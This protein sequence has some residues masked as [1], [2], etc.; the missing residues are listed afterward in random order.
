VIGFLRF[1]GVS[2]AAIWLGAVFFTMVEVRPSLFSPEMETLLGAGNSTFF[3]YLSGAIAQI[4]WLRCF[5][6]QIVCAGIAWL[7]GLAEWL[8]LGR[9]SRRLSFS[10]LAGLLALV[11]SGAIIVQPRLREVQR[12]ARQP[13]VH[14]AEREAAVK[15][16]GSWQITSDLLN[17]VVIGGLLVYVW[18]VTNR[19]DATRYVS[20]VKF[21]G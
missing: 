11:L 15:S 3:P 13:S 21:R 16:Y 20:S 14:N 8:Y 5:E 10:L 12:A 7:H 19:T 18:R 1:I 4:V 17:L 6:F 9:P 2:N